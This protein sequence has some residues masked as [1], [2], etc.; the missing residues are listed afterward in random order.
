MPT[1]VSSVRPDSSSRVGNLFR[2]F[3][4]ASWC[5]RFS[6]VISG[7]GVDRTISFRRQKTSGQ[8][9]TGSQWP[10][11]TGPQCVWG[12]QYWPVQMY[13]AGCHGVH[14]TIWPGRVR[15]TKGQRHR[16]TCNAPSLKIPPLFLQ[17]HGRKNQHFIWVLSPPTTTK[18]PHS[19]WEV[20][21]G[22]WQLSGQ[23]CQTND[24]STHLVA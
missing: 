22:V 9:V 23:Y 11:S 10:S 19:A 24:L 20:F 14:G 8:S 21:W 18:E 3:L 2:D 1:I 6:P 15:G 4:F 16:N 7:N 17:P 13:H 5:R 12:V